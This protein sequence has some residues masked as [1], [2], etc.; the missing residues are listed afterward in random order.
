M[1]RT[2]YIFIVCLLIGN[3][4]TL[5][6]SVRAQST[7]VYSAGVFGD[8]SAAHDG[9]LRWAVGV[10]NVQVI[11]S[12]AGNPS[13][14]DGDAT[15]YRHHPFIAWW[16]GFFGV[17][18]DASTARLSWSENGLDWCP[19]N[20]SVI[21]SPSHH[22]RAAFYV[23][24]NG[25]FLASH[26]VGT[27]RGAEGQRLVREIRGPNDYGEVYTIKVNCKG[28]WPEKQWP[29]YSASPDSGFIAACEELL[30]DRLYL[31]QWQ[32][33][34]RDPEFYTISRVSGNDTW[35][36]FS[37]Y[38]LADERIVGA[39]KGVY[40][41]ISTEPEWVAGAVPEPVREQ[42]FGFTRS[43]KTWGSRTEDGRYALVGCAPG[44]EALRR[45]WPL[46]VTT[47]DDGVTFDTPFLV[48]AGDIPAQRYEDADNDDKNSGPQYVRGI[49]PGNGNPPGSELWLSYSMNKEDI[50]VACVPTPIT[51]SVKGDVRDTFE[52]ASPGCLVPGWNTYSPQWAPIAI[53]EEKGN[54]FVRLEDQDPSD[55]ASVMRV[56]PQS[57]KAQLFFRVRAHQI[58]AD[59]EPLEIDVVAADGSRAVTLTL[60]PKQ[61]AITASDGGDQTR[62]A[63]YA[64]NDWVSLVLTI[65]CAGRQ[66]DLH[67]NDRLQLEKAE[68]LE[69]TP[70]VERIVFRT[71]AFRLRDRDRR[72]FVD[73]DLLTDR[74]PGADEPQPASRFDLDDVI[75][76][77]KD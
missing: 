17:M 28:P 63:P 68:F 62:V 23:A 21:F 77:K 41:S 25:R 2:L 14:S 5:F 16:S 76:E 12:S 75:L 38:R 39:W 11:R 4:I 24:S 73:E 13:A 19:Q 1:A 58:N 71:G 7:P 70:S 30:G 74:I 22:H 6:S 51:G 69:Q 72:P 66:Y 10:Q 55:Y 54:R 3:A 60:N 20:S 47:S 18:H 9:R 56:F 40:M 42:S 64:A 65:D 57:E 27:E 36:A 32:E 67:I 8:A 31:Q 44:T 35:K 34:D 49:C 46:A 45:R 43:A 37:W 48:L 50:W 26:W 52:D 33:E 29:L 15:I 59:S 53:A 61:A